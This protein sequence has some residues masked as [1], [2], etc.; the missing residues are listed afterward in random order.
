MSQK[1]VYIIVVIL[2]SFSLVSVAN[3]SLGEDLDREYYMVRYDS[4]ERL[5]EISELDFTVVESYES[6]A[7]IKVTEREVERIKENISEV[8]PIRDHTKIYVK[9]NVIDISEE[10][11]IYRSQ[12]SQFLIRLTGPVRSE[13]RSHLQDMDIDIINYVP[14]FAFHVRMDPG[15]LEEINGLKFVEWVG[16]YKPEYKI[17]TD[18]SPGMV[19]IDMIGNMRTLRSLDNVVNVSYIKVGEKRMQVTAEIEDR[20][21]LTTIAD[22]DEV[23]YIDDFRKPSLTSEMESQLLGGFWDLDDPSEVYRETGDFGAYVNHLGYTGEEMIIAFADTGIGDGTEGDSGH[24]DFTDRVI[25]G[26]DFDITE[27]W[28]D[29]HGHGTHTTGLAVGDTYNGTG[30][31]YEGHAPYY[32]SQ[33]LAYESEIYAQKIFD[34]DGSW[35]LPTGM[36]YYDILRDAKQEGGAYI[37]SNSWGEDNG[38][39][40]YGTSDE[41]Y[42]R[43]V[44]DSDPEKEGNQPMV[45][46]TSAGN[47][48]PSYWSID[49]PGNAKN[50]ITVGATESYMPDAQN[51]GSS[52]SSDDPHSIASFSSR[53]WTSDNRVKPTVVVPGRATLSTST[54]ENDE[55]N[56]WGIYSEDERYEWASGTSQSTPIVAGASAV[57]SQYYEDNYGDPPSPAMVK[58]FLIN[59]AVNL[60][61]D[62]SGDGEIDHVPNRYEG[63]GLVDITNIIGSEVPY[64]SYDQTSLLETGDRDEY[65]IYPESTDEPFKITLTWTDKHAESG[66]SITLKN[67]LNLEVISPSGRAYKGNAFEDGWTPSGSDT[68]PDFDDNGDGFDDRNV[69]ENVYIHPDDVEDG[70]YKV[71]VEGFDI[72]E[73]ANNDG[74]ANQ[75]Y[76]LLISNSRE[77]TSDGSIHLD[78]DKYAVEDTVGITVMDEDLSGDEYVEVDVVSDSDPDGLAVGLYETDN[79][80]VFIGDLEISGDGG[81]GILEVSHDDEIEAIYYDE[82]VGDGTSEEK[83]ATAYIDGVPPDIDNVHIIEKLAAEVSLETDEPAIVSID[84]GIDGELVKNSRT[85]TYT[86]EHA[87]ILDDLVPGRSYDFKLNVT[88]EVGNWKVYDNDGEY[89]ELTSL[90]IDDFEEGNIGWVLGEEWDVVDSDSYSGSNSW[91]FGQGDYG[92]R[93]NESLVSP[94]IDISRWTNVTI[95]WYHRYDFEDGYDGGIIELNDGSGW[96]K[97][98]P[99]DGYDDELKE[100]F[101][102]PLEGKMAFTGSQEEWRKENISVPDE[103]E[104][105]HFR[106]RAGTDNHNQGYEG[107]WID[108]I[109]LKGSSR[110]TADFTFRPEKPTRLDDIQFEDSSHDLQGEVNYTWDFDDGDMSYERNPVKRYDELGSFEV[111]LTV[112]DESGKDSSV[113]KTI[114]IVNIPPRPDFEYSPAEPTV[115]DEIEFYDRSYD[116]DGEIVEYTWDFDD[117]NTSHGKNVRHSFSYSGSYDVTLLVKDDDGAENQTT[118]E[119]E[120]ENLPPKASFDHSPDDIYTGHEVQF[121]DKSEDIDGWITERKWDLGDGNTSKDRDPIHIYQDPG[122]YEVELTVEDNMGSVNSTL[123]TISVESSVPIA[124]F[125]YEPDNPRTDEEVGFFDNSTERGDQIISWRWDFDDGT[126]SEERDPVHTFEESGEYSVELTVTDERGD[127]NTTSKTIVVER[128]TRSLW[129]AWII[130]AAIISFSAGIGMMYLKEKY[131]DREQDNEKD[132]EESHTPERFF[133]LFDPLY[134][135]KYPLFIEGQFYIL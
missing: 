63:W 48:G 25:G 5:D 128:E 8:S 3:P 92:T 103:A 58:A 77:I 6:F 108:L 39:G 70:L 10:P 94:K 56:L 129:W 36:S 49:S 66:D 130:S 110:P 117:G 42:D 37:H 29:G 80:G 116:P 82:D 40:S 135:F 90:N 35:S 23:I 69:V 120:I 33:G 12:R 7:I 50:V 68:L 55:S 111:E 109:E 85:E 43:A 121:Y 102:N 99:E 101:S 71:R 123:K 9:D 19:S 93:L 104:H 78:Q 84:Y 53:G 45:I 18:V 62:H 54:P 51:Y 124:D 81:K 86:E 125:N 122:E 13:W 26:T 131:F 134:L 24:D 89:Y 79:P 11:T 119:I 28:S 20:Q 75:D 67:D 61:R 88:D 74:T 52:G 30:L 114:E 73:D 126:I 64:I 47:E 21:K 115:R 14:N 127:V 46:V 97:V 113:T 133:F 44:R 95:S 91:N 60:E 112:R 59:S 65:M 96:E 1:S 107:W 100:G 72:P 105:I 32:L 38:D 15:L 2:I 17:A 27:D 4:K 87:V 76:S 22:M 16:E 106:F 98:V 34:D 132:A 57:I 83:T 118:K 31:Q 41:D